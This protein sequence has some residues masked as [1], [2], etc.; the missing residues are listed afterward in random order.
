MLSVA[1]A[2]QRRR[3]EKKKMRSDKWLICSVHLGK[4]GPLVFLAGENIGIQCRKR[5]SLLAYH[6]HAEELL[7]RFHC[8]SW[9][10]KLIK[11]VQT[12]TAL[13]QENLTVPGRERVITRYFLLEISVQTLVKYNSGRIPNGAV[14]PRDW[15][16]RQTQRWP[17]VEDTSPHLP[18]PQIFRG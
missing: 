16:L 5:S 9:L 13:V 17:A 4:I 10:I 14:S 6:N 7:Q 2:I 8:T 12:R 3:C 15:V 18:V 1:C 11:V